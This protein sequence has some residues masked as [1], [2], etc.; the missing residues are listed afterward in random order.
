[1]AC[2]SN[3]L[4]VS[5]YSNVDRILRTHE[6]DYLVSM[7]SPRDNLEWPSLSCRRKL[8]LDFDDVSYSSEFGRA[9]SLAEISSLIK[10]FDEWNGVGTCLIHC[11]AGTS[12]SPAAGLIALSRVS[13]IDF[14]SAA[15]KF[16]K[17]KAYF[18][19]NSHMLRVAD[20]ATNSRIY[21]DFIKAF[22]PPIR[23]DSIGPVKFAIKE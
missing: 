23:E 11:R 16:M 22:E 18:M 17:M 4:I 2:R 1:M 10:L 12:R 9:A 3:C 13:S 6:V 7:L 19:P 8:R 15:E 20:K 5:P 21:S 14:N